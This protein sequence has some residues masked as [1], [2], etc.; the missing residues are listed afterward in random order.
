MNYRGKWRE[1]GGEW[2]EEKNILNWISIKKTIELKKRGR[3]GEEKRKKIFLIEL[4]L[5]KTIEL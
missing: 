3:K 1:V 5:E 2:G 4:Q